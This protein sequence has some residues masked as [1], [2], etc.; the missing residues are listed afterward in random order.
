[1]YETDRETDRE[2]ERERERERQTDR[3]TDCGV[4]CRWLRVRRSTSL[5]KAVCVCMCV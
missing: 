3:Q 4:G 1:V 5:V 2:R